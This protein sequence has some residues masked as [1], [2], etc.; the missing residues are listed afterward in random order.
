[1]KTESFLETLAYMAKRLGIAELVIMTV[2]GLVC[3]WLG[4][5]SLADYSTALKVGRPCGYVFW[6]D[7]LFW[8]NKS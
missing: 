6:D 2:T 4:W 1:M 3:W 7:Q 5:R 8:R